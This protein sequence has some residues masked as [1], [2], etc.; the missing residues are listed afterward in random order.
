MATLTDTQ[1]N[2][3]NSQYQS[4]LSKL[5]ETLAGVIKS[6]IKAAVVATDQWVSDNK[7]SFNNALPTA[8]K[9]NLTADQKS[10]ILTYVVARRFQEGE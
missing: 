8:A 2:E 3:I 7:V 5:R 6:D 4:D 9:D 10:R 1:H